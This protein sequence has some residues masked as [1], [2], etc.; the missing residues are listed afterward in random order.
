MQQ[1]YF[2][3][4]FARKLADPPR[5]RNLGCALT[6]WCHLSPSYS[7]M[8]EAMADIGVFIRTGVQQAGE[9]CAVGFIG[10]RFWTFV[11]FL[12]ICFVWVS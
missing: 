10:Y 8:L 9:Y 11:V 1:Q 2:S 3:A 6:G 12:C 4:V 5:S 7:N